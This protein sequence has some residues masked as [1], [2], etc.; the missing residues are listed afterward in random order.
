[1]RANR[2]ERGTLVA[3]ALVTLVAAGCGDGEGPVERLV[4]PEG[5]SVRAVADTLAAHDV[6]GWPRLFQLYVRLKGADSDI[7][8]GTYDLPRGSDWS[9]VLDALVAGRVVTVAVTIPEGWTIRQVAERIAPLTQLPEDTIAARLLDPTLADSLGAPGPTLEGF[10]FPETYRFAQGVRLS[11]V[12]TELFERYESVW[13]P[14]RRAALD[15]LGMTE[16]DLV[17]LA[18]IIQA[19][20]R[21]DDEMPLISAVFHNRLRRGMRLQA[22]PTVQYVLDSHQNRLLFRHIESVADN[23]YNTYTHGGL[24]P[25]PIGSPGRAAIDAALHPADVR[26]LYFVA[27]EDGRHEFSNTLREHNRKIR[28]IRGR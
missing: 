12:A 16:R 3:V 28:Q 22:D 17:T 25:G 13:T 15:S 7:K 1:M 23:P 5:T 11:A 21:W 20:A 19:E 8:A 14:D 6:I 18:S 26:Y 4:I 9:D 27:R 24:P 2:A 10:L